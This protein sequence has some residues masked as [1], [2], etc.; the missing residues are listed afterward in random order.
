ME[1]S[2]HPVEQ[3]PGLGMPVPTLTSPPVVGVGTW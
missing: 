3:M 2:Q 1:L